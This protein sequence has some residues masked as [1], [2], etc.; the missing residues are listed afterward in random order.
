[1]PEL[2]LIDRP[3]P[4]VAVL[5]VNRP[6]KYNALSLALRRAF[7]AAMSELTADASLRAIVVTGADP[8][9]CAGLDLNELGGDDYEFSDGGSSPLGD[10]PVPVIAAVNGVAVTGGLEIA[11]ACDFRIASERARF[12]DTHT[13]VGVF[14]GWGLTARLPQAVGQAWARQM[15][16]TGDYVD[17]PLALRIGL[18][19]EVVPH[20][21]LL[22]RCV[23]VAA[24]IASTAPSTLARIRQA[25]DIGRDGTG[26]D[27]LAIE[28]ER[29]G[30]GL[31][32]EDPGAFAARRA[33]LFSRGKGQ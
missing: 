7:A 29:S 2:A 23:A 1:M 15:S 6:E 21:E 4:G 12:A 9:F 25:Y 16:F 19:N 20:G 28:A 11:L 33:A 22:P 13:R 5:T 26:A 30:D 27:S 8:A 32:V 18:V 31:T 3:V 24:S 17:A 14:P 10:S